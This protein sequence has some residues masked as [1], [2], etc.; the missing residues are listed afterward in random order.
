MEATEAR[1]AGA[2]IGRAD[3]TSAVQSVMTGRAHAKPQAW[4]NVIQIFTRISADSP[5]A[6]E[7]FFV[8]VE[9]AFALLGNHPA[10]G[11][12]IEPALRNLPN[13][14]SWPITGF[15]KYLIIYRPWTAA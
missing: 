8:A 5:D 11:A 10:A 4:N 3:E 12:V 6:A 7:R 14:R 1:G 2:S 15:S 13:A 9:S